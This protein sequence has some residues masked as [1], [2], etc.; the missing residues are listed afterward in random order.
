MFNYFKGEEYNFIAKSISKNIVNEDYDRSYNEIYLSMRTFIIRKKID[1]Y[2]T[3]LAKEPS[4]EA[5][6]ELESWKREER[7]LDDYLEKIR[8]TQPKSEVLG[9]F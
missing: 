7:K 5:R 6:L 8:G 9:A 1:Y 3:L 4:E 2:I